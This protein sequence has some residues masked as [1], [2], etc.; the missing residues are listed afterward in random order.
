MIGSCSLT[1]CKQHPGAS[2]EAPRKCFDGYTLGAI[3]RWVLRPVSLAIEK[4]IH[5]HKSEASE[6]FPVSLGRQ[7]IYRYQKGS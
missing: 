5:T 2:L 4:D 3:K 7:G 1:S 6:H